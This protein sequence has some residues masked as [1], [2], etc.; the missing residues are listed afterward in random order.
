[1]EGRRQQK[2]GHAMWDALTVQE[3]KYFQEEAVRTVLV[4]DIKL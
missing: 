4:K 3:A 2:F 1:M